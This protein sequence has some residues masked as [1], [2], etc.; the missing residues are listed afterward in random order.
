MSNKGKSSKN[1]LLQG[2]ILAAASIIAKVIGLIYRIPLNNILGDIGVSYYSSANEIYSIILMIS[3]FSL[4]LAVSKLMSERIHKGE[5]RNANRVFLCAVRFAVVTGAALSLFTYIF[6]GVLSKYVMNFEL[7]KH[8]LRVLAPAIFIFAITGTF[9]GFFQG[10]SNMVPTAVSQVIEQVI[11]AVVSIVCADIMFSYGLKLAMEEDNE[12]LGPAWG[13]AGATFGTV[14]SVT[15]ALLFMMGMYVA[16][17]KTL[18][19]QLRKDHTGKAESSAK[20]YSVLIATIL[21][22]ILSTLIYN[23][24]NVVD[25]GIFNAILKGQGYSEGQ[26]ATIWGIYAGKF[27]V[28]M[29]V[30][31]AIASCLGPAVVPSLTAAMAN[32]NKKEAMGK[33]SMSIRFT[34]LFTIPCALGMAALGGPIVKMLF[35]PENGVPLASGIM[36]AGALLI[37]LLALSTLTTAILQGLGRLQEPLIHCAIALVVHIISLVVFMRN[38]NLNIYGVIYSNIVFALIICILNALSIKRYLSYRQEVYRTFVVPSLASVIMAGAAYGVYSL[39]NLFAGNS[40]STIIAIC[41]G[42]GVYMIGMVAFK[43]ITIEELAVM[44]KG[45]LIIKI[46]RKLGLLR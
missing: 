36:Q 17:S 1:F 37:I 11:N 30:P 21:P 14:V 35:H 23:I 32:R 2:S 25:Q 40:I 12:L 22:I 41:A 10:Y 13:A 20:I 39:F 44:P 46:F 18:N 6:A 38:L 28:L 3:S 33:V 4:P 5:T 8:A 43:G 16:F 15:V 42:M 29:N 45:N 7:A 34:M 27:R 26:Y 19:R 9:R 24:S 31:L